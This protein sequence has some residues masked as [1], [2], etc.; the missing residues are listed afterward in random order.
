MVHSLCV[1][2][3]QGQV[4]VLK[5]GQQKEGYKKRQKDGAR[6]EGLRRYQAGTEV[7]QGIWDA[8]G[9]CAVK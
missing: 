7:A 6:K 2:A 9:R 5:V 3:C 4:V 8:E 1:Q